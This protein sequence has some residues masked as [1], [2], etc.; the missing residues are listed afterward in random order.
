MSDKLKALVKDGHITKLDKCT[1]DHFINPIAIIAK[2]AD[3]IT[4]A[5]DAKTLNAQIWKN[6]YQLPNIPELIDSAA[7]ILTSDVPGSVW[8]TS[9]DLKYAVSQ[10]KLL[11]STSSHCNFKIICGESTGT[12]IFNTGLYG[13]TDMPSEFQK[14]MDCTLQGI[15]RTIRYLDDILVVSMGTLSQHNEIVHKVL[16]RLDEE[17]FALKLSKCE[18]AVEKL[19]WLGFDIH[20]TGYSPKF[21]KIEIVRNLEAPRT[22]K[23]LRSF[24]GTLNHFQKFLPIL[25]N[26]TCEFRE[27]FKLCNKEKFV[28]NE[29]QEVAF[30]KILDLIAEITDL[31]HYDPAKKM[32]VKCDASHSGLGVCLE[33]KKDA[34]LW[35]TISFASRFLLSAELKYSTNELEFLAVFSACEHSALIY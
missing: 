7:Q 32:R 12:F 27:S 35:V 6:K 20:S 3:S 34:R 4:L 18:F 17:G 25:R 10:I 9:L 5:M 13:S 28:R 21:S 8:F 2:K 26:L 22:L 16:S 11:K 24:M 31:F 1:T 14:A 30:R 19:E 15:P 29:T 33:Q 23:Q